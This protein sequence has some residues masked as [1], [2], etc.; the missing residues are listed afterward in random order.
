MLRRLLSAIIAAEGTGER[1]SPMITA[2]THT[3]T[4]FSYDCETPPEELIQRALSLGLTTLCFTEHMDYDYPSDP[5]KEINGVPEFWLDTQAYQ[6]NFAKLKEK[7]EGKINLLCGVEL[8]LQPHIVD[9]NNNYV[10]QYDFDY[11]IG[12]AHTIDHKDP[13]FSSFYQGRPEREAYEQYFSEALTD[14][15]LFDK[16]DSF[17]H[18]DYVVRYG[19]NQNKEYSFKE[20][21]DFIDPILRTLIEKGIALEVNTK[22]YTVGLGEPNPARDVL[23]RYRQLGGEL[24]T[25]GSDA[26]KVADLAYDFARARDLLTGCGFRY[27]AVFAARSATFYPLG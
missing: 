6:A 9:W 24:I 16:F 2:D 11:I 26:H 17:G 4:S 27:Y 13:F 20:Y 15:R 10:N 7:Y 22:G 14:I 12:S 1:I 21:S 18:L 23:L 19:P 8:G 3:H 5:A 25:I